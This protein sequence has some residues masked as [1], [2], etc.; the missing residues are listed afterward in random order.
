MPAKLDSLLHQGDAQPFDSGALERF[1]GRGGAVAVCVGLDDRQDAG[2]G[3]PFAHARQ[4]TGQG[5]EVDLEPSGA[6]R[7]GVR[8]VVETPR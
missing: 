6:K 3:C 5:A 1:G 2:S 8:G 4:V 7:L